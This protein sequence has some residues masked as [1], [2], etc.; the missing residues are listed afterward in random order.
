[1]TSRMFPGSP[2]AWTP[3]GGAAGDDDVGAPAGL[4]G[5]GLVGE[6]EESGGRCRHG[7]ACQGDPGA[8]G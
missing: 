6:A 2:R 4:Q 1:M 8:S 7:P 5:V 3:S